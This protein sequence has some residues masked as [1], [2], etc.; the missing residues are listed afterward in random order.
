MTKIVATHELYT[1]C[2][3]ALRL[4]AEISEE[5]GSNKPND[6]ATELTQLEYLERKGFGTFTIDTNCGNPGIDA[7]SDEEGQPPLQLKNTNRSES[8]YPGGQSNPMHKIAE[9]AVAAD[10][11][12]WLVFT[13]M[14]NGEVVECVAGFAS[15]L[16]NWRTEG[17]NGV[18]KATYST[19]VKRF[20]FER[21]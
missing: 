4:L 8:S 14:K 2:K 16:L 12:A 6:V 20:G 15:A 10:P 5:T 9:K 3:Q 1:K 7:T 18:Q 13:K 11:D 21:V 19:L 17:G